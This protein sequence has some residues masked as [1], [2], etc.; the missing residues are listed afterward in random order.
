MTFC[1][2]IQFISHF[3]TR[4]RQRAQ[5]IYKIRLNSPSRNTELCAIIFGRVASWER[6]TSAVVI[7]LVVCCCSGRL[8]TIFVIF[9]AYGLFFGRLWQ[10]YERNHPCPPLRPQNANCL[11]PALEIGWNNLCLLGNEGILF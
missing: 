10:Q 9:T 1:I 5:L 2:P 11:D 4:L 6:F 8:F 7:F 3:A